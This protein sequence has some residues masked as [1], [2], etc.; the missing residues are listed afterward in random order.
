MKN[1]Q[2][3]GKALLC[4]ALEKSKL[5]IFLIYERGLLYKIMEYS[6][7]LLHYEK[8][9]VT[10]SQSRLKF[11]FDDSKWSFYLYLDEQPI[12]NLGSWCQTCAITLSYVAKQKVSPIELETITQGLANG[13]LDFNT[14]VKTFKPVLPVTEGHYIAT[15]F[16]LMPTL[17]DKINELHYFKND[18]PLAWG[19]YQEDHWTLADY[20]K[21]IYSAYYKGDFWEYSAKGKAFEFIM[22]LY[23]TQALNEERV[24][25]YETQLQQ[26]IQPIVISIGM[27]QLKYSMMWPVIAD[28]EVEPQYPNHYALMNFVLDGHH[29]LMAA[30]RQKKP[31]KLISFL[32]CNNEYHYKSTL[33]YLETMQKQFVD[34]EIG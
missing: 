9:M 34:K 3:D 14:L 1:N 8:L 12:Y 6:M 25:F 7:K 23:P 15:A 21:S 17:V 20:N 16:E 5:I 18:L 31:V 32:Y 22:P 2:V 19:M 24:V 30:H 4:L 33:E 11:D 26:G 29:K 28:K 10:T 27:Q 13:S